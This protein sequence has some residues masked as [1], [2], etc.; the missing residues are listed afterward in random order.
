MSTHRIL[1]GVLVA[2]V[3]LGAGLVILAIWGV[4]LGVT[5]PRLLGTVGVLVGLCAFLLVVKTD[6]GDQK[7]LKDQNFLD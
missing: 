3:V 2:L 5:L 7:K 4:D 1:L 6:F